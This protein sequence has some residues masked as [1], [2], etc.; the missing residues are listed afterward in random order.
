MTLRSA[1]KTLLVLALALPVVQ[2]VLAWVAGLLT[3][4]G[5]AAGAVIVC[6]VATTCQVTWAVS[7]V[8][9]V[10]V[11]ALVVLNEQSQGSRVESREPEEDE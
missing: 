10:I 8:G 3:G 4:M 5:D 9:L 2:A 6:H 7:L 1:A 11:L